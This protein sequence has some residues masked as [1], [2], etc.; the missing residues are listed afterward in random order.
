MKP[1]AT[2]NCQPRDYL[3]IIC[4]REWLQRRSAGWRQQCQ[5]S[6]G[7]CN[8]TWRIGKLN[9]SCFDQSGSLL[10]RFS[11]KFSHCS[12]QVGHSDRLCHLV[13]CAEGWVHLGRTGLNLSY[14]SKHH[15]KCNIIALNNIVSI[16]LALQGMV[17]CPSQEQLA[18]ILASV[19]VVTVGRWSHLLLMKSIPLHIQGD[20]FYCPP[21]EFAKCWPVSNWFQKNV[22]VPDWPPLWLKIV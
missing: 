12:Q 6:R 22:R 10:D 3:T 21:P 14:I 17:G 19:M 13:I 16:N 15:S 11:V 7:R 4:L 5:Q 18:A 2:I 1:S 20:F 9:S 8:S